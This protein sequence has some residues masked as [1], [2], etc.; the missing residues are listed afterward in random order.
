[1]K[2][3][4]I[5]AMQCILYAFSVASINSAGIVGRGNMRGL[6]TKFSGYSPRQMII[7][8]K[9]LAQ[10]RNGNYGRFA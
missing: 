7:I 2:F 10:R 1:M 3:Q 5:L 6:A 4:I 8:K 9:I